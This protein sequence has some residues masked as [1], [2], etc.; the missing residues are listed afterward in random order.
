M[1]YGSAESIY[2][3][4]QIIRTGA[5]WVE[6]VPTE[7]QDG[8]L[9]ITTKYGTFTASALSDII[10]IIDYAK[11]RGMKV[12]LKPQILVGATGS[13]SGVG[14]ISDDALL[15]QWF[16]DYEAFVLKYA[17]IA[18]MSNVDMYS[19]STNLN[20]AMADSRLQERWANLLKKVKEIYRNKLVV[21]LDASNT[22]YFAVKWVKDSVNINAIGFDTY[23][24]K[25]FAVLL[26]V[27]KT[28]STL[29][30]DIKAKIFA[31]VANFIGSSGKQVYMTG[32]GACSGDCLT[33]PL[34]SPTLANLTVSSSAKYMASYANVQKNFTL[35]FAQAAYEFTGD[36]NV[37]ISGVFL[38]GWLTD[39]KFGNQA[40]NDCY[41]LQGKTS[42]DGIYQAFRDGKVLYSLGATAGTTEC[43][44]VTDS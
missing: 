4:R 23:K 27:S 14:D 42:Y 9:D 32:Y 44:C 33:N 5:E 6:I 36:N 40:D 24:I 13:S 28:I 11:S 43:G 35:A 39:T 10:S 18:S 37:K 26:N 8:F 7:Y 17:T 22:N 2:S 41:S 21:V 12:F 20:A 15:N 1:N 31:D 3:L 16:F 29:K 30:T 19:V 34:P 38:W 25:E